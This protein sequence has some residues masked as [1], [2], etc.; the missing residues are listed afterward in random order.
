MILSD[1]DIKK[2]LEDQLITIDP[3][4]EPE[5]FQPS[6][7][8]LPLGEQFQLW[9]IPDTPGLTQVLDLSEQ[10]FGITARNH[11]K[12]ASL[13]SD[14][15]FILPPYKL[16][17]QVLLCQTLSKVSL[18]IDSQIAARVEGRSSLARLGLMVH[19][20][21][22]TIHAGFAGRITLE[23]IN[24]GP[25][26]LRLVPRKTMICQYIFECVKSKPGMQITTQF[27]GQTT[28]AGKK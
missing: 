6:A 26:H 13:D 7:L 16:K 23:V 3:L 4:P 19:L 12:N 15:C 24:H 22:P 25:F 27:Q 5:H 11:I 14:G 18:P 17:P 21:A 9:D 28:P 1:A 10:K 2:A 8:D 20:T